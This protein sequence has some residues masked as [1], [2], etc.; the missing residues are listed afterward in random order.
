MVSEHLAMRFALCHWTFALLFSGVKWN[1]FARNKSETLQKCFFLFE[2]AQLAF[3]AIHFE[4]QRR[5]LLKL[6]IVSRKDEY[7][8]SATM[9]ENPSQ[10]DVRRSSHFIVSIHFSFVFQNLC[11][12]WTG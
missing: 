7:R 9:D 6:F 12:S 4:K 5:R 11:S 10:P 1:L 3:L 8:T 2:R